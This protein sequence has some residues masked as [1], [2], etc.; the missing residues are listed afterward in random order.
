M[1]PKL[2]KSGQNKSQSKD[3][4]RQHPQ[5]QSQPQKAN[6]SQ[7]RCYGCGCEFHK[8]RSRNC[9]AWG[10]TC[11][12]CNKPNHWE[13]LC[14]QIPP[15]R[16]NRDRQSG[17][18]WSLVNEVRNSSTSTSSQN[19]IPKQVLDIV[20]MANSVDN[21]SHCYKRQLELDTPTM[22]SPT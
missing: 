7:K 20:N 11:R 14:G 8:D 5:N 12:K 4:M 13:I 1:S 17:E 16:Q 6:K 15:R 22:T 21:L 3:W 19:T 10:S 18:S 2:K 9:P